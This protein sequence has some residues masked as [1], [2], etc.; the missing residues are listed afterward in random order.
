MLKPSTVTTGREKQD[1]VSKHRTS[2]STH[3]NRNETR[4]V[5]CLERRFAQFQGGIDVRRME[6]LQIV[7]YTDDQKVKYSLHYLL[8]LIFCF[9]T[10][11]IM[12]GFV[13]KMF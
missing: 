4:V 10:I 8:L 13:I 12:I 6:P 3:I 7:K 2:H 1:F 5:R 9:S 11:L